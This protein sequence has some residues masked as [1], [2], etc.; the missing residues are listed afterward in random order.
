M[1]GLGIGVGREVWAKVQPRGLENRLR[2]LN[3]L[4]VFGRLPVRDILYRHKLTKNQYC[5]RVGCGGE[6]SVQHVFWGCAFAQ[7]VWGL[8]EG[9]Y[10]VLGRVTREKV[11]WGEGLEKKKGR[12]VSLLSLTWVR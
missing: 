9:R 12:V 10:K 6:E 5:P 2:D 11:L 1:G 8:V 3:W 4:V 7:E